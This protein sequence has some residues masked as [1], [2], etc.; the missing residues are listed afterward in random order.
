[1]EITDNNQ[2]VK[3]EITDNKQVVKWILQVTNW[4]Y[5]AK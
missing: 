5:V 1:M 2:V 4:W 3:I